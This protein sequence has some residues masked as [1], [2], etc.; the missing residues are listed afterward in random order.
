MEGMER[1][2]VLQRLKIGLDGELHVATQLEFSRDL[3]SKG[4]LYGSTGFIRTEGRN[5]NPRKEYSN[6]CFVRS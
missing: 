1:V 5:L 4:I 3:K 6:S 2:L